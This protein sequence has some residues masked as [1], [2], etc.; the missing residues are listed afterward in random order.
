MCAPQCYCPPPVVMMAPTYGVPAHPPRVVESVPER[1]LPPARTPRVEAAPATPY[2]DIKPAGM[3]EESRIPKVNVPMT[4]ANPMSP[5][6]SE[7]PKIEFTAPKPDVPKPELPKI[8]MPKV[9]TNTPNVPSVPKMEVPALAKPASP[10]LELPPLTLP[11]LERSQSKYLASTKLEVRPLAGRGGATYSI[12]F[13]NRTGEAVSLTVHGQT[14][15]LAARHA[16]TATVPAS[17]RWKIGSEDEETV[18]VADDVA[19]YVIVLK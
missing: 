14:M 3:T 10:N 6:G 7:P 17:F 4:P 1:Q 2:A 13:E 8:E 5:M 15:T 11:P 9:E 19:G 12:I 16:V 18:R